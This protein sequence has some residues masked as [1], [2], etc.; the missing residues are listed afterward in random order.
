MSPSTI[1]SPG[2]VTPP[3]PQEKSSDSSVHVPSDKQ[4]DHATGDRVS[5]LQHMLS[6]LSMD[7]GAKEEQRTG[8]FGNRLV[9]SFSILFM[10]SWMQ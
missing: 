10:N 5:K 2:T 1:Q 4:S 6:E 9:S 8:S 3:V 7:T